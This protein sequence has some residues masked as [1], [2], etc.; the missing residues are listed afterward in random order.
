MSTPEPV[1]FGPYEVRRILGRGTLGRVYHG[2][3]PVTG[4][5]VA[6]RVIR[7]RVA[8]ELSAAPALTHPGIIS[9]YHVGQSGAS[10][11]VA[12]EYAP[13]GSLEEQLE[14]GVEF[15]PAQVASVAAQ[16][17]DALDYAHGQ[18]VVHQDVR[19]SNILVTA[20]GRYKLADFRVAGL[21]EAVSPAEE[22]PRRKPYG[23]SPEQ[24]DGKRM[25]GA[26]DQFAL[27]VVAYRLLTGRRPFDADTAEAITLQISQIEPPSP[28]NTNPR[29][30]G[31]LSQVIM[32]ALSKD[33]D[34]RYPT[35]RSFADALRAAVG[36]GDTGRPVGPAPSVDETVPS[37]RTWDDAVLDVPV[38][39]SPLGTATPAL[40]VGLDLGVPVRRR[41]N[42][43]AIVATLVVVVVAA[44]LVWRL[45]LL[46]PPRVET[47]LVVDSNPPDQSLAIW[48]DDVPA[49]LTTPAELPLEGAAGQGIRL[50]LVRD[51]E[52]VASTSLTLASDMVAEWTPDVEVPLR[53]SRYQVASDPTGARVRLD[54]QEIARPTPVDIDLFPGQAYDI[55]V[56]LEG[57]EPRTRTVDPAEL[58]P[59]IT[60]LDFSLTRIVRPGR[61]RAD[62]RFPVTVVVTSDAGDARRAAGRSPSFDLPPGRYSVSVTAPDVFFSAETEITIREGED[63]L[64]PEIPTAVKILVFDV[65]GNATVR[66]DDFAPFP[67]GGPRTVV[68]GAHQVVFEWPTGE[69]LAQEVRIEQDGQE[70]SAR[71]P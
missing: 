68:V 61:L 25:T 66:I 49:G 3:D 4:R 28:S 9:I 39:T 45:D 35:C 30:S 13:G 44:W 19:P 16:V 26:V 56:E 42:F 70:V 64:L 63:V 36:A 32:Q 33:P 11:F 12:M 1:R 34:R 37:G 53:P 29:L 60:S 22:G 23:L 58:D 43:T 8:Q 31:P 48:L 40:D 62:A 65:P 47:T 6:V 46:G 50:D 69:R 52:V 21:Y 51:D 15:S 67:S 18:G 27:A 2:E 5:Q 38:K 55:V 41:S 59:E 14:S 10:A 57:Y 71:R 17:A 54:G 24:V 20:D 7:A